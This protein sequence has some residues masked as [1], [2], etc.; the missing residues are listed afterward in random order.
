MFHLF[1]YLLLFLRINSVESLARDNYFIKI[2]KLGTFT[3]LISLTYAG[4]F[5]KR[6]FGAEGL[7]QLKMEYYI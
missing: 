2:K 1:N 4:N 6:T 3:I 7:I 5:L